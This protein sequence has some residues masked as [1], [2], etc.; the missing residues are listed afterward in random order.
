[1]KIFATG[2]TYGADQH[3]TYTIKLC[4][5]SRSSPSCWVDS[6][7]NRLFYN[8]DPD[9]IRT[10][11]YSEESNL[12]LFN[13]FYKQKPVDFDQLFGL[14]EKEPINDTIES[15]KAT[16][17]QFRMRGDQNL[18]EI[19]EDWEDMFISW[20]KQYRSDSLDTSIFTSDT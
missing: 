18:S 3:N 1:M 17:L 19:V 13:I 7:L 5:E 4:R 6:P 16:T 11:L 12:V 9:R 8:T 15:V 10:E 20:S 14:V 2:D